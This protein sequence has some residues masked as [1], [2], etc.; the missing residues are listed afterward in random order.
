MQVNGRSLA[1]CLRQGRGW[2]LTTGGQSWGITR[3][4]GIGMTGQA[5]KEQG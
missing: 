4:A 1:R 2:P 3:R 5:G